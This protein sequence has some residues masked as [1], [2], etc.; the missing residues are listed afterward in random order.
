MRISATTTPTFSA[1]TAGKNCIL[2]I[3]PSHAWTE[4]VKSRK[5]SVTKIILKAAKAILIFLNI[6]VLYY[7]FW[8][9]MLFTY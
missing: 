9:F 3:H 6:F 4:P 1:N 5:S 2:A 7:L 8:S